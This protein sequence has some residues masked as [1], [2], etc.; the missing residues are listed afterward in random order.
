MAYASSSASASSFSRPLYH[1]N[2][3]FYNLDAVAAMSSLVD[4]P[5]AT[6]MRG[7]R[8]TRVRLKGQVHRFDTRKTLTPSLIK[9]R[10]AT[11]DMS[12]MV[13]LPFDY[14]LGVLGG[15]ATPAPVN[16]GHC[17]LLGVPSAPEVRTRC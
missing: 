15:T 5:A 4:C 2:A 9:L 11:L 6:P 10:R 12:Q 1:I 7:C 13:A 17:A 16:T 8:L 3:P 14:C